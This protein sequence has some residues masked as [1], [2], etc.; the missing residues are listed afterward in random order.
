MI[1]DKDDSNYKRFETAHNWRLAVLRDA[2]R[3]VLSESDHNLGLMLD[4]IQTRVLLLDIPNEVKGYVKGDTPLA[5]AA[6]SVVLYQLME[7]SVVHFHQKLG[8]G[9]YYNMGPL[10]R[11]A[12]QG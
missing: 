8:S 7:Q 1:I 11:L 5:Y 10:E 9:C 6:L 12:A 2:V 4:Q 3:R